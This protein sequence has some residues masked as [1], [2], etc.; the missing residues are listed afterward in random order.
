MLVILLIEIIV[1]FGF[2]FFLLIFGLGDGFFFG[3]GE[4]FLGGFGVGSRLGF[5]EGFFFGLG[6]GF[7]FGEEFRFFWGS[8]FVFVFEIN[9]ENEELEL[10]VILVNSVINI[11]FDSKY[12]V[13]Y[14]YI[15]KW[16]DF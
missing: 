2:S 15:V 6:D 14:C 3:F 13:R 10:I 8:G 9:K 7:F 12:V 11:E 4:G 1:G 16:L 5:G